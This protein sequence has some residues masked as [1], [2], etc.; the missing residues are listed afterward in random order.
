MTDKYKPKGSAITIQ[1]KEGVIN[2]TKNVG[3]ALNEYFIH[4]VLIIGH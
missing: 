1:I 2:N 4:V 3:N